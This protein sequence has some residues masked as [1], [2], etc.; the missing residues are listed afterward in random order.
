VGGGGGEKQVTMVTMLDIQLFFFL[1][2]YHTEN[3]HSNPTYDGL[4]TF[5]QTSSLEER[6]K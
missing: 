2:T 5:L 4:P 6:T 1:N 3:T